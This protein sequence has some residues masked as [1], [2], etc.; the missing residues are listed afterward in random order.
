MRFYRIMIL[1]YIKEPVKR[2]PGEWVGVLCGD[3]SGTV[4]AKRSMSYY[5][6]AEKLLESLDHDPSNYESWGA[7]YSR[8]REIQWLFKRSP[9]KFPRGMQVEIVLHGYTTRHGCPTSPFTVQSMF[10]D[11][12]VK[13]RDWVV[14]K[15][16]SHE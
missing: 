3:L 16:A 7:A 14:M 6:S 1:T 5:S 10:D 2:F 13:C 8:F 12:I 11:R 15:G 4:S 9:M